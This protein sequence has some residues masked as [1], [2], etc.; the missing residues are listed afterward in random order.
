MQRIG[1][2]MID[3]LKSPSSCLTYS[4]LKFMRSTCGKSM[5]MSEFD[6]R[7]NRISVAYEGV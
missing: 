5:L 6:V 7:V 1:M 4:T 3:F 2:L